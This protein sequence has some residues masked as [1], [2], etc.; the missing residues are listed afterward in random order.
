LLELRGASGVFNASYRKMHGGRSGPV[1]W[2][3]TNRQQIV[4]RPVDADM[5][6]DVRLLRVHVVV[7]TGDEPRLRPG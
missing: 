7:R 1:N 3:I 6:L 5:V 2:K 4:G